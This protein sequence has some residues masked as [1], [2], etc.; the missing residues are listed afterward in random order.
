MKTKKYFLLG[1]NTAGNNAFFMR[2]NFLK[3][4]NKIIEE[5]KIFTSKFRESRN[6]NGNLTFLSKKE[7]LLLI[8]NQFFIDLNDNKRKKLINIKLNN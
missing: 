5:K 7:S 8:Q 6:K 3:E 4:V 2:N 1:T